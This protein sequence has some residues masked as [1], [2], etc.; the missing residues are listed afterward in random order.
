MASIILGLRE[1]FEHRHAT[2]SETILRRGKVRIKIGDGQD[3]DMQTNEPVGIPA[4]MPHRL[5]NYGDEY[6]IV[7]CHHEPHDRR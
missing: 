7:D 1:E 6:A 3:R 5:R 4:D 2:E